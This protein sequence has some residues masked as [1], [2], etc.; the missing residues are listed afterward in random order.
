[1]QAYFDTLCH[2]LNTLIQGEEI[3]LACLHGENTDFCRFNHA[4]MRQQGTVHQARLTVT[5]VNDQKHG[6][7]TLTLAQELNYDNAQLQSTLLRLRER[8]RVTPDD[9]FFSIN[10]VVISNEHCAVHSTPDARKICQDITDHCRGDDVVGLLITGSQCVG[11][12]NAL[13][14]RN[15]FEAKDVNLDYS[16]YLH[17]DKAIKHQIAG[18]QWD[19]SS[20]STCIEQQRQQLAILDKTP[21]SLK[22]GNYRT[23]LSPSA[24]NELLSLLCYSGFSGRALQE[25]STPLRRLHTGDIQLN[26]MIN[27]S[28]DITAG[29][30]PNFQSEGFILP[31]TLPLITSGV[32]QH[33]LISPR[34]AKEFGIEHNS[35][36]NDETPDTLS[37]EGG[38]LPVTDAL[39][40]LDTGIFI[41]NLWYLNY[42]D[43]NNARI[44]G[45]T[46]FACFW[47][48]QGQIKAPISALRFDD[49][50]YAMLG[51]NLA[52]LTRETET[53][54]NNNTYHQRNRGSVTLPGALLNRMRFTL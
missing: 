29:H 45:M 54:M 15:W 9:P 6:Q 33:Q 48:E 10:D 51:D 30:V 21:I 44:T 12:A 27:L 26:P 22:P 2:R 36:G 41:S 50:L 42:S 19:V 23:Y 7:H 40:A 43:V 38:T 17:S 35:A 47:V 3:W 13:G 4:R 16:L 14:Q 11:F 34:T 46:R 1:M 24:M 49:N 8:L 52:A 37:L 5:L 20:F 53:L 39:K 32:S 28:V 25:K 31:D 18:S